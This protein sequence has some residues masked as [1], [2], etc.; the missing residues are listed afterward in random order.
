MR[1]TVFLEL[2]SPSLLPSPTG[3]F[4][5]VSM[6]VK[7]RAPQ[8][9][10]PLDRRR[11]KSE[12][13]RYHIFTSFP[14]VQV[15]VEILGSTW[16]ASL[17]PGFILTSTSKHACPLTVKVAPHASYMGSDHV[18]TVQ[19]PDL[20]L[21]PQNRAWENFSL[22][23]QVSASGVD[24]SVNEQGNL[25]VTEAW[26]QSRRIPLLKNRFDVRRTFAPHTKHSQHAGQ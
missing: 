8:A 16:Q 22:R 19:L 10:L 23:D 13:G 2:F 5:I 21:N 4:T 6:A 12:E 18:A 17:V 9:T 1:S 14:T 7:Q 20:S 24:E 15:P 3:L 25:R 26:N 11:R